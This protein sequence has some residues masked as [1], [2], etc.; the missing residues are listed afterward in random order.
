MTEQ[1]E[2]DLT[3]Y[4]KWASSSADAWYDLDKPKHLPL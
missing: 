4:V 1:K 3:W 2:R